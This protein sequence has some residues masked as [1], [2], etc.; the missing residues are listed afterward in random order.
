MTNSKETLSVG[1]E[2][3]AGPALGI[4]VDVQKSDFKEG[5]KN[6]VDA[7]KAPNPSDKKQ[8]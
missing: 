4:E 2:T 7:I 8:Q 6:V 1:D 5:V 3:A